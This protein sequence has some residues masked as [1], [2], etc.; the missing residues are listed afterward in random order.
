TTVIETAPTRDHSENMLRCFGA[1]VTVAQQAD[2]AEA[3]SIHGK[4]ELQGRNVVV[5]ADPSSA[6]FPLVAALL[7]PGSEITLCNVGIN[8]RRAGLIDTLLEMG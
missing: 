4:P 7:R 6:A 5:P 3:I 2:G 8:P 1:T